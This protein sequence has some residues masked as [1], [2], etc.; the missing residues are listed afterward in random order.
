MSSYGVE[1]KGEVKIF[2]KRYKELTDRLDAQFYWEDMDFENC[3]KL[4]SVAK[5]SGGKRLPKGSSYS[6][7]KTAFR[8][9]RVGDID[10]NGNLDY[11]N[12]EYLSEE[13]YQILKNYEIHEGDLML[14]M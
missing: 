12:F 4:S 8:Y 1:N 2:T 3:V 11:H 14:A 6:K 5:V 9:L 7:S 13:L 10:W